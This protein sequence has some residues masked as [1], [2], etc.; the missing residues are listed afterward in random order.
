MQQFLRPFL[1]SLGLALQ[2]YRL[3]IQLLQWLIVGFYLLLLIIPAL[4]PLPPREAQIFNNLTLFAQFMFWGIWCPLS[5]CPCCCWG[6][7][8][9][10]FF[11]LKGRYRNGQVPKWGAIKASPVG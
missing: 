8:G 4:S 3:S 9:A 7:H 2:R 1:E 6:E 10:A 11:V 5:F